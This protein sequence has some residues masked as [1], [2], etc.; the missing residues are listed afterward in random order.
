MYGIISLHRRHQHIITARSAHLTISSAV[1]CFSLIVT[2]LKVQ[3][4][5]RMASSFQDLVVFL[6]FFG[7]LP[8]FRQRQLPVTLVAIHDSLIVLKFDGIY[9]GYYTQF[10]EI[11]F[12]TI[13]V[14]LNINLPF[15]LH[16]TTL[17]ASWHR[18]RWILGWLFMP[19][20]EVVSRHFA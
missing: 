6:S 3:Y 10:K 2:I 16:F 20:F 5:K 11:T 14:G 9:L 13:V 1:Q 15:T 19:C 8:K 7:K 4:S 12:N 17:P 18:Q